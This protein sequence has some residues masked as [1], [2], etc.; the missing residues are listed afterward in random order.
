MGGFIPSGFHVCVCGYRKSVGERKSPTQQQQ[1]DS[2]DPNG[3]GS[4]DFLRCGT[5]GH[6]V[7][8]RKSDALVLC[9]RIEVPAHWNQDTQTGKYVEEATQQEEMGDES[10]AADS[11][12]NI[13]Q[14]KYCGCQSQQTHDHG[15]Q[16]ETLGNINF[17]GDEG[18]VATEFM[19]ELFF[20]AR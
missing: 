20:I 12:I 11:H 10:F 18:V 19:T 13:S 6:V 16:Q 8:G 9:Y 1:D 5:G 2:Y 3:N 7:R 4:T 17:M 15:D 14:S